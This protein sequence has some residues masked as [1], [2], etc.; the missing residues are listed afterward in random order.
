[1]KDRLK[2]LTRDRFL[3]CSI[4]LQIPDRYRVA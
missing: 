4:K 2:V 1:M 3:L